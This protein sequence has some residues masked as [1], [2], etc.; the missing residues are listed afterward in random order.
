MT[1]ANLAPV[2]TGVARDY[3]DPRLKTAINRGYCVPDAMPWQEWV[4]TTFTG[5]FLRK[6]P[7]RT[8][9]LDILKEAMGETPTW[10][11]FTDRN[12]RNFRELM[13]K[14]G[15]CANSRRLYFAQVKAVLNDFGKEVELP[16]KR[17]SETLSA[18][19]EPSQHVY[20]TEK[21]LEA[22]AELAPAND[23]ERYVKSVFLISAYTGARHSDA[24]SITLD[25]IDADT[26]TLSYVSQKTH[27]EACVPVHRGLRSAIQERE[28]KTMP[29]AIFNTVLRGLCIRAKIDGKTKMFE[30]GEVHTGPKYRF[31]A[32]HT[33]RRSFVT[34]L[35]LRG[36]DLGTIAKMAGH[37]NQAMTERYLCATRNVSERAMSFFK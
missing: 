34:N 14:S 35:Y 5:A 24:M 30:G 22:I 15:V 11:M 6:N 19:I 33:A 37:T 17:Y 3:N 27:I 21:E 29:D 28:D 7:N 9:V 32:S 12:M 23:D 25:N 4:T 36:C 16:T 1:K 31:V 18:K 13:E 2:A 20:L 26:D 10:E 8:K